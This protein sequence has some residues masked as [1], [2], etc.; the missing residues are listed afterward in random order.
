MP[1]WYNRNDLRPVVGE[2]TD[3]EALVRYYQRGPGSVSKPT[4]AFSQPL[5]EWSGAP[6]KPRKIDTNLW[7]VL[8][9]CLKESKIE[10]AHK[11]QR[12]GTCVGQATATC[13]DI[14]MSIGWLLD[15]QFPGR[16]SVAVA[17]TGGRVEYA[18]RP[19]SWQ[20]SNGSWAAGFV[21][22]WG[23]GLLKELELPET[24]LLDD[25]R[26]ALRWTATRA[27]IPDKFEQ[28]SRVRPILSAPLITNLDEAA[29][30]IEA[31]AP[32]IDCSNLIPSGRMDSSGVSRVSRG[33]GHA[34][35]I[36]AVRWLKSGESQWLYVNS[37][38]E[39]WGSE[40]M[41]WLTSSDF[42]A[43]LNQQDSYAF[44]GVGG[45]APLERGLL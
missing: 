1:R 35:T 42:Q 8:R 3:L 32:I 43:I 19:G 31:G 38:S 22:K 18:G 6:K 30:A 39:N 24:T 14:A 4:R 44:A 5:S 25:E 2:F 16:A 7:E 27:G 36:A 34:T 37:W 28:M 10:F 9:L 20:G 13:S 23:V 26:L 15:K 45:L 40:G 21:T 33:G 11:Y 17:Y 12:S 41:V 29:I